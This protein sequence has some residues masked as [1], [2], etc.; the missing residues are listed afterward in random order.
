MNLFRFLLVLGGVSSFFNMSGF[1]QQQPDNQSVALKSE[2]IVRFKDPQNTKLQ[3]L[4]SLLSSANI[5]GTHVE[6]V[7][8]EEGVIRVK[9]ENDVLAKQAQD[10]L[11]QSGDVLNVAPIFTYKPALMIKLKRLEASLTGR[12]YGVYGFGAGLPTGQSFEPAL[13]GGASFPFGLS[14]LQ[15]YTNLHFPFVM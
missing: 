12:G 8:A 13:H 6:I 5:V 3:A 7:N 10:H 1:A 15:T 4:H 14:A 9:F 2:F 11:A